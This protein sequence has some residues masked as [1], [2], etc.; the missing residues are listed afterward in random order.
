MLL[1]PTLGTFLANPSDPVP[2]E[3]G[4]GREDFRRRWEG[5]ADPADF[6]R[7]NLG[8]KSRLAGR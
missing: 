1:T 8:N 2:V 6:L 4:S 5:C 7:I 3:D